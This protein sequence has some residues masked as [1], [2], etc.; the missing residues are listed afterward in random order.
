MTPSFA[1]CVQQADQHRSLSFN[2]CAIKYWQANAGGEMRAQLKGRRDRQKHTQGHWAGTTA[3]LKWSFFYI[4]Q[5]FCHV[6]KMVITYGVTLIEVVSNCSLCCAFGDIG[7]TCAD[8]VLLLSF[9]VSGNAVG[10]QYLSCIT[11]DPRVH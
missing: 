4:F 11:A 9:D 2:T 10:L 7:V 5:N 6:Q 3:H 8:A 1:G